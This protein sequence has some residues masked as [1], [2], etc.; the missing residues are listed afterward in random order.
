MFAPCSNICS[1]PPVQS[2]VL[3][4]DTTLTRS[5]YDFTLP[6]VSFTSSGYHKH[7]TLHFNPTVNSTTRQSVCSPLYYC[8]QTTAETVASYFD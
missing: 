3:M 2:Y 8:T 4:L 5:Q 1:S 7:V 6:Q